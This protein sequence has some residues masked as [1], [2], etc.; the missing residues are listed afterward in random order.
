MKIK[1]PFNEIV[2]LIIV[3]LL[4]INL[5]MSF[6]PKNADPHTQQMLSDI[7]AVKDLLEAIKT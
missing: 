1:K 3:L 6:C 4:L 7:S 2:Q 5:L